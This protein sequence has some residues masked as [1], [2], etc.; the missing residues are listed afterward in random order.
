MILDDAA[1]MQRAIGLARRANGETHPNPLVG[2]VL[3]EDGCIMAEGWHAKAGGPHAE[4]A[5]LSALGRAPLPGATL[6]VTLEPCSTHGRTPPCCEAIVRAG[7]KRVVV[8][9][10]DPNPLHA[11]RGQ[12]FLRAHGVEVV[13]GVLADECAGLNP[14][15]NHVIRAKRPLVAAKMAL[16][17]DGCM[18]TRT[19]DSKWITGPVAQAD[20]MR[21][22]RYFP[23][24]VVGAGTVSGDNPS[25]TA[26]LPDATWC[27]RRFV[28]DRTLGS[29]RADA[30]LPAL[31]S[32]AH[33]ARTT[34]VTT[35]DADAAARIR[36]DAAGVQV[37]TL[38]TGVSAEFLH[39]FVDRCG[40][41]GVDGIYVEGGPT[42]HRA[43]FQARIPGYL[44]A[45]VAPV[46]LGDREGQ[47]PFDFAAPN[48]LRE[49]LRLGQPLTE[50]LGPDVLL[51]GTIAW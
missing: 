28:L 27:P 21:W 19:G 36:L 23:S 26:R 38:P 11:G 4:V 22:R 48:F 2:A 16:T 45:Y 14:I 25:L 5:A 31:Y 29:V 51:R 10:T 3:V 47:S 33:V 1:F 12:A 6:Y 7:I 32:D 18:A 34:V 24:I 41:E 37:W 46:V 50:T 49:A 8:G 43:L 40:A 15:F 17:L 9:A 20:C 39:A 30:P 13:D 35:A 44:F 42:L